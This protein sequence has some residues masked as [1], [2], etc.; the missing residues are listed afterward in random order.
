MHS[1]DR[2]FPDVERKVGLS[3]HRLEAVLLEFVLAE[4]AGKEAARIL[5]P[6]KIDDE[7]ASE[8]S[9]GKNHGE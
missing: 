3:D 6:F 2:A 8:L 1:P 5:S 4:R 9:L 7:R